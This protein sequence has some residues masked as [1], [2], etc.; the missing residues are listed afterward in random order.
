MK[1]FLEI[2]NVQGRVVLLNIEGIESIQESIEDSRY[3]TIIF[4]LNGGNYKTT[5]TI[6]QIKAK[7]I[8]HNLNYD[9][10]REK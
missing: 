1:N 7:L 8:K 9:N 2:V 5:E 10:S 4:M 3:N 6:E